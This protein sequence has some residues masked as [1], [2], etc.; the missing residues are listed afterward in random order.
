VNGLA[1]L[2]TAVL[3][4]ALSFAFSA[5]AMADA[6]P[7][8]TIDPATPSYTSAHLSGEVNPN[9]GP[10]TTFWELQY[11]TNPTAGPW[12]LAG[13]GEFSGTEAEE[14]TPLAVEADLTGLKPNTTYFI[15]VVAV[16]ENGANQA[17]KA[18]PS[19]TTLDVPAPSI[20]LDPVTTF[21]T[22]AS[23][24]NS[25]VIN[26]AFSGFINPGAPEAAPT[27]AVVEDAFKVSYSF[28]CTPACP[29]LNGQVA[30]D[31]ASHE[32]AVANTGLNPGTDYVVVLSAKNAG[33]EVTSSPQSFTT[34]PAAPTIA[35]SAS[36]GEQT[37]RASVSDVSSTQAKLNVLLNPG[38]ATTNYHFEYLE[39]SAYQ[40]NQ[41]NE[42]QSLTVSATGGIFNLGFGGERTGATGTGTVTSGSNE[43]TSLITAE[44]SGDLK[45]GSRKIT[46]L[47]MSMGR[48]IVSQRIS[49]TG[50]PAE[51][52]ISAISGTTLTLSNEATATS[53]AVEL[54]SGGP[55]PFAKGETISGAGI[56]EG[57]TIQDVTPGSLTLS[58]NAT[59][60]GSTVA[61]N[62]G[63][64]FDAS[65]AAVRDALNKLSSVQGPTEPLG[66]VKV[67]GG[68]GDGTGSSPYMVTFGGGALANTD[69][70]Q[71]SAYTTL[72]SGGL[73]T[74]EVTTTNEGGGGFDGST[75]VPNPS[76][77]IS[78]LSAQNVSKMISG[79]TPE[80]TYRYRV[81]ASNSA[82]E[83]RGAAQIFKTF[84]APE[85]P[86]SGQL[87]GQGFLPD[88]R[89]WEMV[90]PP[91]KQGG[92]V[93]AMSHRTRA[94]SDGSA[95]SFASLQG[96]EDIQ[97]ASIA[98][99]YMAERSDNPAP[100]NN[101]WS[102]H[103]ITPKQE[104]LSPLFFNF[105]EPGY[106]G[107]LSDDLS[108]GLYYAQTDLTGEEPNVSNTPNLYLRTDLRTPGA[109][110]YKLV[111]PC[112]NQA[113]SFACSAHAIAGINPVFAGA[114]EDFKHILFESSFPRAEGGTYKGPFQYSS[115]VYEWNQGD[116]RFGGI[117]PNGQPSPESVAGSSA[118]GGSNKAHDPASFAPSMAADGSRFVFTGEPFFS[119]GVGSGDQSSVDA[120]TLYARIAGRTTIQLN[121]SERT[122]PNQA[123]RAIFWGTSTD[124]RRTFFT[125]PES[126]T[127]DVPVTLSEPGQPQ[128]EKL[129]M[130]K[131]AET[132]ETQQVDVDASDGSF[133]LAFNEGTTEPIAFDAP[134]SAVQSALETLVG[135][136]PGGRPVEE[137]PL[138]GPGNVSVT[139]G[140]GSTGGD[141]PYVVTFEGDFEG[142]NVAQMSADGS[143]LMGGAA[144]ATVTT[145]NAVEN[146]TYIADKAQIVI[147]A[148]DD[149]RFVYY[150]AGGG[151]YLWHEGTIT[152]IGSGA[153]IFLSETIDNY[154]QVE[155]PKQPYM[156]PDGRHLLFNSN[157]GA[158]LLSVRGGV[159]YN[160]GVCGDHGCRQFYLYSADTD[161]LDCVSCNPSGARATV[162]AVTRLRRRGGFAWTG[163]Y[164]ARLMSADGRYSFFTTAERLVSEDTNGVEDAY[165]YDNTTDE[166]A[167][168]SSGDGDSP[169]YFLDISED[170]KDAFFATAQQLS[171]WDID[172]AYDIYDARVDGGFP[173]PPAPPPSCAG[174]A[175]QPP[176][177]S[178]NDP[179]PASSSFQGAGNEPGRKPKV[180]CAKGKHKVKS[181]GKTRCVATKQHKRNTNS[182]RRAGR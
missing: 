72:L 143:A 41:P 21:T 11:T 1:R 175:C 75:S 45:A 119:Y 16:N 25:P 80:T 135:A 62:S 145:T 28:Q 140:P 171:G 127:E 10:S 122:V 164:Q 8:V 48:F 134:A 34:P 125:S 39:D 110:S 96:F 138:I 91:N 159:D 131:Q 146:L 95:L 71:L 29:G 59:A 27:S 104:S 98:F 116:L 49:G 51:T 56:P 179:T 174:D 20:S 160:Q 42:V 167:L 137:Q 152:Y 109:G 31:N 158:G 64:P 105:G 82:G 70:A 47:S 14:T 30:A 103:G 172:G 36:L 114:S 52:S 181:R 133:T 32:V 57:T 15:R 85:K 117:L 63:L 139:G 173:E 40:A 177:L 142:A 154:R 60:S 22:S 61:L 156:T 153:G 58:A 128:T 88:N 76:G 169:A 13:S 149:G 44:G 97:G 33:G 43:I 180:R 166:A 123:K 132:N 118:S 182:N 78:G 102:T 176:A 74:A 81:F 106:Q 83:L 54:S 86:H 157:S 121:S 53:S 107:A 150:V 17:I 69:V 101:G 65:T 66:S 155:N 38:N 9:G 147:D 5:T 4:V 90:S 168:I 79:L 68:P 141:S 77:E 7:T 130:W 129:Y 23:S 99:E 67:T 165:V 12:L 100:G 126:L 2:A 87:P 73:A 144:T 26:A 24:T 3:A 124:G 162:D 136:A 18:G 111:T 37:P 46:G 151:L 163:A 35:L 178:L 170:G 6:P 94:A 148:S 93:V 50:I 92:E 113:E 120:G 84:K 161:E 55:Q 115:N 108:T 19:F 112:P 89:A